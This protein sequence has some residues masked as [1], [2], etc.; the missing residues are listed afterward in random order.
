MDDPDT[1]PQLLLQPPAGDG[2]ALFA[3]GL[4]RGGP[5]DD[6]TV[7]GVQVTAPPLP[8]VPLSGVAC[9]AGGVEWWE[10]L[11][12]ELR[13]ARAFAM[14][15]SFALSSSCAAVAASARLLSAWGNICRWQQGV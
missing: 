13:A 3:A 11:P 2:A 10:L 4:L 14:D 5:M 12:P 6:V 7:P 1:S 9:E 15:S 8:S